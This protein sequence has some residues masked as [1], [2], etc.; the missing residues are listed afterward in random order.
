MSMSEGKLQVRRGKG[1]SNRLGADLPHYLATDTSILQMLFVNTW[2]QN[3]ISN[4]SL[5][6]AVN[7]QKH[8]KIIMY[9]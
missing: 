4:T 1:E 2:L 9:M 5:V 6:V 3:D 8:N 7:I